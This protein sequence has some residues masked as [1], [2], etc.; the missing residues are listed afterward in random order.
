MSD[1]W[2]ASDAGCSI[3]HSRRRN[4]LVFLFASFPIACR[5]LVWSAWKR[6]VKS[7]YRSLNLQGARPHDVRQKRAVGLLASR[8]NH[9]SR[10]TACI[11]VAR[12]ENVSRI[13][14]IQYLRINLDPDLPRRIVRVPVVRMIHRW[15]RMQH[16]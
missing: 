4:Q 11:D 8:E 15:R 7:Q 6:H 9:T 3:S 12:V 13:H 16:Q 14:T 1:T 10:S 5:D 2:S